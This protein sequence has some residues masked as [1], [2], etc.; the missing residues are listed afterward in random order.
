V[1]ARRQPGLH[2]ETLSRKK[3]N[4]TNKQTKTKTKTKKKK[5]LPCM[6]QLNE[7]FPTNHRISALGKVISG[8]S[9]NAFSSKYQTV[10]VINKKQVLLK[11]I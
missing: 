2:R 9:W 4:Q 1:S 7:I 10:L 6:Q 8:I 3:P 5:I 11:I